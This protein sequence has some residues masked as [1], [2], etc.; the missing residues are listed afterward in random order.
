MKSRFWMMAWAAWMV[1]PGVAQLIHPSEGR[2][3]FRDAATHDALVEKAAAARSTPVASAPPVVVSSEG[4]TKELFRPEGLL[5]RSEMLHLGHFAT[6]VPKRAV[7]HIPE[8]RRRFV[9]LEH[10][11]RLI[12]WSEFLVRNRGWIRTME[13]TRAQAEG[14]KP[15]DPKVVENFKDCSEVIVATY[16]G[17]PISVLPLK[18]PKA[19]AITQVEEGNTKP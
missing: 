19:P 15:L 18:E 11:M 16:Q 14:L 5:A 8:C 10:G 13:V 1:V 12:H 9:G 6:L 17:G 2:L 3:E 4:E 7:L